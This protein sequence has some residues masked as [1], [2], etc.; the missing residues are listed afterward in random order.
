MKRFLKIYLFVIINTIILNAA[1][2]DNSVNDTVRNMAEYIYKTTADPRPGSVGGEWAVIG[3]A[4]SGADIPQEYYDTYYNN[5]TDY[6][7]QHDGILHD[8][9][10]TE[11]SRVIIAL[12]AIGKN[13]E[14]VSGYNLLMPLGDYNK[15]IWQGING[16]I[17][18]L[19]ALDSGGYDIPQ[20]DSAQIQATREMYINYI[21][22]SQLADGGWALSGEVSDI[23]I[24]AMAVQALAKYKTDDNVNNA[25]N[26]ALEYISNAQ[27]SGGGFFGGS[28]SE[29]SESSENTAQVIVAL[30]CMGIDLNDTRFVKNNNNLLDNLM[31]YYDTGFKHTHDSESVNQMA[32]EQAFYSLAALKRFSE[33]KTSL[34]D[35]SDVSG[36]LFSDNNKSNTDVKKTEIIFPDKTFSDIKENK[37]RA[38]IESLAAR[39]II[40]GKSEDIFDP[41]ST[42]TRAEFAAITVKALGLYNEK[43]SKNVFSDISKSDW[44]FGYVTSAY[45]YGIING[46]SESEFNPNG[47]ITREEAA[48]MTSRAAGICGMN[49][50]IETVAARNILAEFIDYVK[51]SDWAFSAS[52]FCYQNGILDSSVLEINPKE[53]VT[54]A[55]I[56]QMLFNMLGKADLL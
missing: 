53:Y 1:A 14:N 55:E 30:C 47:K 51:I 24:T 26:K 37:N 19:T 27:N 28:I 4:R 40:N 32:S 34:Y 20:N 35:M 48:V 36:T 9:K 44:F 18:A 3:L 54:R 15:T 21:L 39:N 41:D 12:A 52:A 46:V 33:G 10:Y 25:L 13:P 56:A 38:A 23:D 22:N 31:T 45:E 16:P 43:I 42:M 17:W 11:Y 6:L 49:T 2:A 50:N 8:K 29:N 7:K 5:L